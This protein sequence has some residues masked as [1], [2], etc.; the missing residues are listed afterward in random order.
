MTQIWKYFAIYSYQI[1]LLL[2]NKPKVTIGKMLKHI[3]G[4]CPTLPHIDRETFVN[5]SSN[6]I[7]HLNLTQNR[8]QT[9]TNDSFLDFKSFHVLDLSLRID[10]HTDTLQACF[11]SKAGH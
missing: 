11:A 10:I 2:V 6:D 5:V 4:D 1:I 3:L 7:N 9:I 8:I